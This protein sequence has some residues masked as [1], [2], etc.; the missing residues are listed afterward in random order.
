MECNYLLGYRETEAR[1][2]RARGAG[3]VET[4]EL[5]ENT[6]ELLLGN[7]L[8]AVSYGDRNNTV[9]SGHGK[10]YLAVRIAVIHGVAE[11]IIEYTRQLIG[12]ADKL[13]FWLYGC[14]AGQILLGEYGIK[15]T[16]RLL[17]HSAQAYTLRLKR[18]RC[19]TEA[20]DVEKFVNKLLQPFR[21]VER[22]ARVSGAD[23]G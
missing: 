14:G 5:L 6:V 10:S 22:Y 21:L 3:A 13:C 19:K 7:C 23:L 16:Y 18:E 20:C 11:Q 12:V 4:E 1:A 17:K 8:S 15:L 2:A 9:C